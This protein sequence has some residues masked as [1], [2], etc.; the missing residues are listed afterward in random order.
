M[1]IHLNG[2]PG[3]G[4]LTIGRVLAERLGARLVDNHLLHDVAIRCA[5]L[6]DPQRWPLYEAVRIAAYDVLANRPASETFVMTNA[7]C[8]NAPR[9]IEAWRHVVDLAVKRNAVLI[10]VVLGGGLEENMRRLQSPD[11]VGRKLT[12]P[13]ALAAFMSSGR[14][15]KPD[16]PELLELDTTGLFPPDSAAAIERHV[17]Q[18]RPNPANAGHLK[19]R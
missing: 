4:K 9:E 16:V 8:V 10:P 3:I 12:D 17:K 14:L 11:R 2:W 18:V 1:I 6:Q 7:L 5:G 13:R 15:Q 19:F